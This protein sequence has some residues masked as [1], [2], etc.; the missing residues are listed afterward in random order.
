MIELRCDVCGLVVNLEKNSHGNSY[1][2]NR[3]A[4]VVPQL[5][6]CCDPCSQQL[7]K[8]E[9]QLSESFKAETQRAVNDLR[10]RIRIGV[11]PREETETNG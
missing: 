2:C 11:Q 3:F 8:L 10:Y 1:V 6:V 9:K 4:P 5:E 7:R